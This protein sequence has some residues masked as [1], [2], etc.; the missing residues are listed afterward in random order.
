MNMEKREDFLKTQ[1]RLF[2]MS[3]SSAGAL[4]TRSFYLSHCSSRQAPEE[5]QRG[6]WDR[7]APLRL[8]AGTGTALEPPRRPGRTTA[9]GLE[10]ALRTVEQG[11]GVQTPQDW[12]ALDTLL[13]GDNWD[14]PWV[15]SVPGMRCR[16]D[17]ACAFKLGTFKLGISVPRSEL[18]PRGES[19][20]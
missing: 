11:L 16:M 7:A 18:S 13:P 10:A 9:A 8:P 5:L 12:A 1:Y 19:C 4:E 15:R 20:L 3:H 17:P 2:L 14:A 6:G